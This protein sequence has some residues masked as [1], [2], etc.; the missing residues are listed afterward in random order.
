MRLCCIK[1]VLFPGSSATTEFS[2]DF[3]KISLLFAVG[4]CVCL[5]DD[6]DESSTVV[7]RIF[8]STLWQIKKGNVTQ[9]KQDQTTN[10]HPATECIRK[11]AKKGKKKKERKT[12][13]KQSRYQKTGSFIN[14][15]HRVQEL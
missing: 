14:I 6:L 9:R 8:T 13:K 2:I 15:E 7:T 12:R 1:R 3:V 5:S 11:K 4:S 10:K